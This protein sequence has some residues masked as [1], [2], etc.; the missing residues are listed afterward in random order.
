MGMKAFSVNIIGLSNKV[1]HFH[2]DF[3]DDFFK[4]YGSGLV[5]E[6]SFEADVEL[7]KRETFIEASFAVKGKAKLICDRSLDPFDYPI[8]FQRKIVFKYGEVNEE[9]SDEII[10]IQRDTDSLELGQYI[11]EFIGLAIPIKKLHPRYQ[12]EQDYDDNAAGKLIYTSGGSS[13]DSDNDNDE[14]IDPRW[15]QLKKL[16]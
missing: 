16:K 13:P 14:D 1:H 6:G 11:Y 5:S 3:G 8:R 15:E 7:D 2:Y 12:D 4:Q 9:L 10:L